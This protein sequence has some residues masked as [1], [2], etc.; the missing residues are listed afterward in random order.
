[1]KTTTNETTVNKDET[2]T[3]KET[4]KLYGGKIELGYYPSRHIY[5][6]DEKGVYGVTG[7]TSIL[8]KPWEGR[9]PNYREMGEEYGFTR[10]R[11]RQIYHRLAEGNYVKWV[12]SARE[13]NQTPWELLSN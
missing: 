3:N 13:H 7:I 10:E 5:S 11:S 4:Y 1:M 2:T 6:V 12:E 8:P 9:M